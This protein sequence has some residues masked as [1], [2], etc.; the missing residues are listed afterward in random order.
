MCGSPMPMTY[1]I[2]REVGK[3]SW[4]FVSVFNST[5]VRSTPN[6]HW[7]RQKLRLSK[8]SNGDP[9]GR[10]KIRILCGG[11]EVGHAITTANNL[12]EQR[13]LAL[14]KGKSRIEF[15]HFAMTEVPGFVD[16]LRGGV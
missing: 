15:V 6:P 16:Y 12:V 9:S 3:E 13:T 7:A 1:E 2:Q 4:H 14:N 8:F 11:K 10:V 5:A